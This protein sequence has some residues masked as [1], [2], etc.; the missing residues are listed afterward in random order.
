MIILSNKE[1]MSSVAQYIFYDKYL[2]TIKITKYSSYIIILNPYLYLY[3]YLYN[4]Q[5]II[6]HSYI[7]TDNVLLLII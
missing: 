5:I 3:L 1:I 7:S 6:L 4:L 2:N